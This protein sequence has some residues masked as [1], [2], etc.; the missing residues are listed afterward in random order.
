MKMWITGVALLLLVGAAV[1]QEEGEAEPIDM[2]RTSYALGASMGGGFA[3]REI[4]VDVEAFQ[5][6]LV[7]GMNGESELGDDEIR[8]LL[9]ALQQN[10]MQQAAEKRRVQAEANLAAGEEF[11]Q[12]N[13][14]RD[15]VT[16]LESGLQY[17]VITAGDGPSP[18]LSDTVTVNYRG[19]LIDGTEFDSSYSRGKPLEM[20]IQRAIKGWQEAI[21]LMTVGSTWKLY[22]P[23]AL[24]YGERG[25]GSTIGPN[26]A[27]IF[28]VELLGISEPDAP[29][30]QE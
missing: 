25:S 22:V 23:P 24:G 11:L 12:G 4:E 9:A 21:P 3:Q 26:S 18:E 16:T 14:A 13:G 15:G 29:Q 27:L 17:E 20:P 5:R 6:G 19:S 30:E 1:A 28:E 7:D 8:E 10:V 2:V